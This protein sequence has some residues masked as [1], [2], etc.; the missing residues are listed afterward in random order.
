MKLTTRT[1]IRTA[2]VGLLLATSAA[3]APASGHA[4]TGQGGIRIHPFEYGSCE[5][6]LGHIDWHGGAAHM[7]LYYDP[8]ADYAHSVF[9]RIVDDNSF[10]DWGASIVGAHGDPGKIFRQNYIGGG[11][12]DTTPGVSCGGSVAV[13]GGVDGDTRTLSATC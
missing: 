13:T 10:S 11:G 6:D 12:G 4:A 1:A 5:V 9:A 8:C 3:F 7:T 2:T